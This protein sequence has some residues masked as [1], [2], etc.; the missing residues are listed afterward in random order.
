MDFQTLQLE[1]SYQ[2]HCKTQT[3]KRNGPK[4]KQQF[5]KHNIHNLIQMNHETNR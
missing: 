3:K 1:I 5:I 2:R 4:D